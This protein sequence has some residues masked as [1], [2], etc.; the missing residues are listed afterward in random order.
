LQAISPIRHRFFP[1]TGGVSTPFFD[2]MSDFAGCEGNEAPITEFSNF[3][4]LEL[5]GQN[6]LTPQSLQLAKFIKQVIKKP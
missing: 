5:A 3:E 1:S 2:P 6:K 4:Q